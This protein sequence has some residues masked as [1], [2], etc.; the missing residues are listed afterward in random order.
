MKTRRFAMTT[1][2]ADQ[3]GGGAIGAESGWSFVLELA[4]LASTV[5]SFALLG[6]TLGPAGYGAYASLYALIGPFVTLAASGSTLALLQHI[7]RDREHVDEASRSCLSISLLL[8]LLLVPACGLAAGHL[9]SGLTWVAIVAIL[10]T[11]FITSPVVQ[12]AATTVQGGEGFI[13]SAKIKLVLVALRTIILITLFALDSLTVATLGVVSLVVSAAFGALLLARVGRQFEFRYL[14]GHMHARHFRSNVAYSVGISAFSFQND[15]DKTVLAANG[16]RVDTGLYA[17]AY[18]IA[19][20]GML[21]MSSLVSAT[22]Q[23]FL[24]HEEGLKGQHLKRALSFTWVTGIYGLVFIGGVMVFAPFLPIIIGDDFEQSVNML[25]WLSP[26]VLF[27]TLAIFPLNALMGLGRVAL[28]T[29]IIVCSAVVSMGLYVWLI[30][31]YSWKGA[32]AGT[33]VSES[34][35]IIALWTALVVM[36]RREDDEIDLAAAS[37]ADE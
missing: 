14:P 7:V 5:L 33:F 6:K 22:H 32:V 12:L 23:R 2:V 34:L 15:G 10:A 4:T 11:E 25:R 29:V 19:Q 26:L 37:A 31:L 20:M 17:A 3:L 28:R 1:K 24:H 27:R 35:L 9:V 8:G 36:Q 21:P 16:F 30:P 13:P 18:R